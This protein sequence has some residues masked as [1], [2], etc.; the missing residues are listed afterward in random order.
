MDD[1]IYRVHHAP[2]VQLTGRMTAEVNRQTSYDA[3]ERVGLVFR[4]DTPV[5]LA[6]GDA[7]R[8]LAEGSM[9]TSF[10]DLWAYHSQHPEGDDV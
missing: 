2:W 3:R 5:P 7:V 4:G 10:L 8:Q 6:I 9:R 1:R